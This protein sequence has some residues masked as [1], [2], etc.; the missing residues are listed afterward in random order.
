MRRYS[1]T[2]NLRYA[3]RSWVHNGATAIL[4]ILRGIRNM[5]QWR[6]PWSILSPIMIANSWERAI[7][8]EADCFILQSLRLQ[9]FES[10]C[11]GLL[12]RKSK[13][14]IFSLSSSIVKNFSPTQWKKTLH[15]VWYYSFKEVMHVMRKSTGDSEAWNFFKYRKPIN[16]IGRM[17][18]REGAT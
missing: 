14:A 13:V 9:T 6:L 1:S 7:I 2:H 10:I 12:F 8:C 15:L 3:I 11:D 16:S 17:M 18:C 5:C 4:Q